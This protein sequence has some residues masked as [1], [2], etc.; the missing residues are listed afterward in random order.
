MLDKHVPKP[1]AARSLR[2]PGEFG[3]E[4]YFLNDPVSV[5][6]SRGRRRRFW[7]EARVHFSPLPQERTVPSGRT[8]VGPGHHGNPALSLLALLPDN[9]PLRLLDGASTSSAGTGASAS[10]SEP[11]V[12][13]TGKSND[14]VCAPREGWDARLTES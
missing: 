8:P 12:P 1:F 3:R 6:C 4:Q 14:M 5:I 7:K 10:C 13:L 9:Q 11:L 2:A